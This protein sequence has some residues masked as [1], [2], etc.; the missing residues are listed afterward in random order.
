MEIVTAEEMRKIDRYAIDVLGIPVASL[1]ENAGRVVAE[2]VLRYCWN[3]TGKRPSSTRGCNSESEHRMAL[4]GHTAQGIKLSSMYSNAR[5]TIH[6]YAKDHEQDHAI[7]V[8]LTEDAALHSTEHWFILTGKGNNG[9]DGLVAARHLQDAGIR[10]TIV[11]ADAP[12]QL[13][14][15]AAEQRNIVEALG[16]PALVWGEDQVEWEHGTGIVD[17]LLGTGTSGAPRSH[18]AALIQAA[19]DS[20]LPIV[21]VDIPSGLDADT[22]ETHEPCIR[23][24]LTVA[25]ACLKRGLTQYPGAEYAGKIVVRYIG[26]PASAIRRQDVQVQ[27]LTEALLEQQLEIDVSRSRQADGHKGTYGHVLVVGGTLEMSGAGLM[28][29]RAALR[30]GCGLV[31]WALPAALLP[32]MIGAAP[33]LMLRGVSG[34][35]ATGTGKT[36]RDQLSSS[37][38]D[39]EEGWSAYTV[40][41]LLELAVQRDVVAIG[42]GLGR[43][44][45]DTDWLRQLWEG[46]EAPLVLD[47]DALNILAD[48]GDEALS[49]SRP[50]GGPVILTPHPGE[51]SRLLGVPTK[52]LQRDRISA[53]MQYA[54]TRR[55]T[56]VL[57]GART[58][59]ATPDGQV[60]VNTTG[61]AG[62]ATAGAGDVL[63]GIIAG[64]LAQGLN[65]TQAA[66]FGVRLHGLAGSQAAAHRMNAASVIAG[67]IIEAL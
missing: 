21:A 18:Y 35:Q 34:N 63:T 11:Y 9:G 8:D 27:L 5:D 57:K 2:E 45:E 42:P 17:A 6:G 32:H 23:A 7:E 54:R 33:E 26:I 60:Y 24:S 25:L 10:V 50:N 56:L 46:I 65:P 4:H 51:M 16:I 64:L 38:D 12:L 41:S 61:H 58:V 37:E 49:W 29:S 47:A 52:E 22:G 39:R 3:R 1:M 44:S 43:F 55:V 28:A 13:R 20:G 67:D 59:V 19:N 31:T 36:D 30:I 14:A 15:E 40:Q 66:T 62:M 48:A 53:A